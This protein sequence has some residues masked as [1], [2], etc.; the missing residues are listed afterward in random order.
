MQSGMLRKEKEEVNALLILSINY[1]RK[2]PHSGIFVDVESKRVKKRVSNRLEC[3]VR[4]VGEGSSLCAQR[5]SRNPATSR[6]RKR[7]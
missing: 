1:Y 6:L 7:R 5:S 2:Q 3:G 4:C